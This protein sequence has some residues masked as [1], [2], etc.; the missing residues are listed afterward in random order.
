MSGVADHAGATIRTAALPG[1]DLVARIDAERDQLFLWVPA[2]FGAGI[3]AYFALPVEP[4]LLVALGAVGMAAVFAW[5]VSGRY[6][7]FLGAVAIFAAATGFL[8]AKIRTLT[9]TAP[10]LQE[11]TG[12]VTIEGQVE[13]FHRLADG[14]ARLFL[15]PSSIEGLTP[16]E[17]PARISMRVRIQDAEASAGQNVTLRGGILPPPDATHPG[18]FD[19]ARQ[20]W[21]EQLGAVGYAVSAPEPRA[22]ESTSNLFDR[23]LIW[24]ERLREQVA[25]RLQTEIGGE[26]GGIAAALVT[27]YRGGI[28]EDAQ[29][30][31]RAAG[32]A[33]ILAI[34]GLHMM[35]VV[36]TLFWS[37]RALLALFPPLALTQPIKK[38]AA[39]VALIGGAAYL[40]ISGAA[41]ATQR[42]FIMA[43]I[44]MIAILVD[45]PAITLRNVAIAALI[46]LIL[47]PE[48]LLSA[49]FQMSFAAT[50]ALVAGYEA[51]QDLRRPREWAD[52][53][54][55][56]RLG[57]RARQYVFALVMTA[58]IAGLATGPYAAFHFNRVAVYGLIGNVGAMPLVGT[59][60]IPPGLMAMCLMPFG[61]DGPFLW[62]MG[63]GIDAVL[64]VARA[65]ADLEGAVRLVPAFSVW[66]L[67]L[68]SL[69][70]LWLALWR[71]RWRLWGLGGI[72]LGVIVAA[73]TPQPDLYISRNAG[74]AALRDDTGALT[75]LRRPAQRFV[76]ERWLRAGA[77]DRPLDDSSLT[78]GRSCDPHAC[79]AARGE[80]SVALIEHP[81]AFAEECGRA[82]VIISRIPLP[83][84]CA[85][86]TPVLA[87]DPEKAEATGAVSIRLTGGG[88][89]LDSVGT[90][91]GRRPWS[92]REPGFAW[93]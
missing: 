92:R 67:G 33:H 72:A 43:A 20:V 45:R 6:L 85:E 78:S 83:R 26:A 57:F 66:A 24:L 37:V 11:E 71:G 80:M 82:D 1:L 88:A 38:W 12:P 91:N 19:Y 23:A 4:P 77:D 74:M 93:D 90:R 68:M 42:A 34:S 87:I 59:L 46:V 40:G 18:G 65:V 47:T 36:G 17:T 5:A 8:D 21:F 62:V 89:V 35:L 86:E 28:P 16:Q 7:A 54:L 69:G 70:G 30:A 75:F 56:G 58:L 49:S 61:L 53:G 63:Q 25:D 51:M 84:W 14:S 9:V 3:S 73:L 27:G 81:A 13:A 55:I 39:V 64:A 79:V 15:R 60:I 52:R 50:I 41:I 32:L 44:M 10:V 76:A 29:E 31:L 2:I 22:S 48:A